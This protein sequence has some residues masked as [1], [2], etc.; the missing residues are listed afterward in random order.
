M[1]GLTIFFTTSVL[2][3]VA[4]VVRS[5]RCQQLPQV[6]KHLSQ[7]ELRSEAQAWEQM[8]PHL[9]VKYVEVWADYS[10]IFFQVEGMSGHVNLLLMNDHPDIWSVRNFHAHNHLRIM[11]T[12]RPVSRRVIAWPCYYLRLWREN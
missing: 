9:T 11:Y 12:E 2:C 5:K 10:L 3:L 8:T 1:I 7:D 4:M 6:R